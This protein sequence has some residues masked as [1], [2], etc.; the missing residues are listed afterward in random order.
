MRSKDLVGIL[1]PLIS[2]A[3]YAL[4][5]GLYTTLLPLRLKAIGYSDSTNGLIMVCYSGGFLLGCLVAARLIRAVGHV[6][7]YAAAAAAIS[8]TILALDPQPPIL[9]IG[10]LQILRGMGSAALSMVIESWLN[11]AVERRFRGQLLTIYMIA[12]ALF[13]AAGQSL[14]IGLE[15]T[16]SRMLILSACFITLALIPITAIQATSP[17]PPR[18]IKFDPLAALRVSPTGML[19]CLFTGL[20][21]ATFTYIGPLYGAAR[22][23][24]Q[25][26]I[27]LLMVATQAGGLVLQWPLGYLSD[28][29]GR[30]RVLAAMAAASVLV[31]AAI[32]F[33]G[34]APPLTAL[35]ALCA[36]FGGLAESFY[37]IGV[38]YANDRAAADEYVSLS[39]NLLFI[40]ALGSMVGPAVATAALQIVGPASFFW[41]VLILSAALGLFIVIRGLGKWR[42]SAVRDQQFHA[43]PPT[44]SAV[45]EWMPPPG[46]ARLEPEE[47]EE[48]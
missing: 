4:G 24:G 37:P 33:L 10:L 11:E 6:R 21:S 19:S 41:Y 46:D 38:A 25:T 43:L 27:I 20:V 13:W 47:E 9:L 14:G 31:A 8:A 2:T 18:S 26:D 35:A 42:H 40:W 36:L 28:N 34:S 17:T 29:F 39:S 32:L 48:K 1:H 30:S 15:P 22:G 7:A 5:S 44:T 16:A 3:F 45:F 23:L 12:L